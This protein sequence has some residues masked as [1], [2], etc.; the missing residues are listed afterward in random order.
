MKR[1]G[2]AKRTELVRLFGLTLALILAVNAGA[3]AYH[4]G[5]LYSGLQG[6]EVR[7]MQTA[8]ISL[9]YLG[10]T[11]DGIF[12]T[13]TE[14]AVIKF[15]QANR[16]SADGV[17]GPK[18]LEMIYKK[19]ESAGNQ[20]TAAKTSSGDSGLFGGNYDTIRSGDTGERVRAL[21]KRL[22]ELGYLMENA[23]G[24]YGGDTQ[25]AVTAFQ[26]N[27]GLT[28]DGLA[29]KRT[30]QALESG[31]AKKATVQKGEQ[32]SGGVAGSSTI[33][34]GPSG[35]QVHLLHWY[36]D[37]KPGL[38][39]GQRVYIYE[40]KSR[41]G[42][43]L[44]VYSCSRHMDA[45]PCTAADTQ[46]MLEAFGMKNTWG[47]KGVYVRLPN[48]AW[49]IGATHTMPHDKNTVKDNNFDGHLCVHFL[50]TMSEC[51]QNDPN[52][53]VSNQKTIRSFWKSITGETISD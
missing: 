13:N 33:A 51:E 25:T 21:Q 52:Y 23:D 43:Y 38:R 40:P 1:K 29:G 24:K 3:L 35:G 44:R 36:N 12:G 20:K 31:K 4:A 9:G 34:S 17:A 53:G 5:T 8:L 37:V 48:G 50:R 32:P 49:T 47:Q 30:L 2:K 7:K 39:R 27:N 15:Q 42:W 10:G 46:N 16:L 45:E 26:R 18:T 41:K 28:A 14:K 22:S 11:A 19:A 6:E